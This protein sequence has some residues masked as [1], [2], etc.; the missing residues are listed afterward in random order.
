[1]VI[2]NPTL[3]KKEEL[4]TDRLLINELVVPDINEPS[5]NIIHLPYGLIATI[6]DEFKFV[7]YINK[8]DEENKIGEF[9]RIMIH[10][11]LYEIKLIHVILYPYGIKTIHEVKRRYDINEISKDTCETYKSIYGINTTLSVN[12]N[13]YALTNKNSVRIAS[14]ED[15]VCAFFCDEIEE[16]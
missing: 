4:N 6:N 13:V 9:Y 10:N 8:I 16:V 7:L 3:F 15:G 12:I 5:C 1:M 2:N 14:L 11:I